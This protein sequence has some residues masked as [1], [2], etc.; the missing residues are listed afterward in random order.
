M[1]SI[2]KKLNASKTPNCLTIALNTHRTSPDN[3]QDII[4]LK[5]LMKEAEIR[6]HAQ[7][8]KENADKITA[9]L[10]QVVQSIDHNYNLDSLLLFANE[11]MADFVRLPIKL[12]Q[13]VQLDQSFATRDLVRAM[14]LE[15]NYY[16]LLLSQQTVRILE[17]SNDQ[18]VEE[19][20]SPFP[21]Q[22]KELHPESRKEK[23]DSARQN[24]LLSEFYNRVDKEVQQ[25]WKVKPRPILIC[26]D[27]NN[28]IVFESVTDRKETLMNISL[29]GNRLDDK[30]QNIVSDAWE[31]VK[32]DLSKHIAA[33]KSELEKSLGSGNFIS[34]EGEIWRAI[35]E[36]KIQTLFLEETKMSPGIIDGSN[37]SIH[38]MAETN[39]K[40]QVD[41]IYDEM[42]EAVYAFGG[43]TIFLAEG[44]LT[45]F[46]GIAAT[47]RY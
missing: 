38:V 45:P 40:Q 31:I 41:D 8:S 11:A 44:S 29:S 7:V 24:R 23:T 9:N 19:F 5:N 28:R 33:R 10:N 37:L 18:L 17:A 30:A 46:Q 26:S 12:V 4:V 3:K 22:N 2:L 21:I 20:G 39:N 36:G 42:V 32:E 27:A 15:M 1:H 25:I 16:I 34:D 6:L 47:T 43:E 35:L 14:H 13:R